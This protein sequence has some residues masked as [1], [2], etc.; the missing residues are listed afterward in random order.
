M[1]RSKRSAR[2]EAVDARERCFICDE[3]GLVG[4]DVVPLASGHW[5][6]HG[7]CH[8]LLIKY[9]LGDLSDGTIPEHAAVD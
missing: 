2:I 1:R 3:V 6:H 8:Q 5:V 7:H 9:D 4:P